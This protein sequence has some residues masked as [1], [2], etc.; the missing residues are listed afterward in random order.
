MPWKADDAKSHNSKCDS[1][2]KAKK[3]AATANAAREKALKDGK[4]E[5]EADTSA[6]RISNAA[7]GESTTESLWEYCSN[8]GVK[9]RVDREN[10]IIFGVKMLGA[11][12]KN[13]GDRHFTYPPTTHAQAASILEGAVSNVDHHDRS[14]GE[15]VSYRDRIGIFR[16]VRATT[17]GV[18]GDYHFN[19]KHPVAEQL[20][21][22]AEHAP[23]KL[24][25]SILAD[26][27]INRKDP[28][29]PVV[30][31]IVAVDSVDL[32][33][34][35]ATTRGLFES[36]D[37]I[38]EDQRAFCESGLSAVSDA[39]LIM[40]GSDSIETK[41]TRLREVLAVWQ[42]ELAG[43]TKE[44]SVMEYKDVTLEG[45]RE[46]CPEIVAKLT[47]TDETSKLTAEV[48][49]LKESVEAKEKALK[50]ANDKLAAEAADRAK[51]A[52]QLA[53]AE[54]LKTAK[55]NVADKTICTDA[56]MVQLTEAKDAATRKPIIDLMVLAQRSVTAPMGGAAPF[57]PVG[58]MGVG[59]AKDVKD[60]M[61]R[62]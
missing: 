21:W 12:S 51:A 39:R 13:R 36:E 37:E 58:V 43:E 45:L 6:I 27:K 20:C 56:I 62:L 23:E 5:K 55:V 14:K 46:H 54:E 42:A 32:V 50:E 52:V 57:T 25:F 35:P 40:L 28:M 3:W 8:A 53:I 41:K 31:A 15:K 10:G 22:D 19:M 30:E 26:G 61:A 24:G 18:I 29:N 38:P 34:N 49:T 17:D 11:Q 33:A 9:P 47:G 4:S 1:P 2:E 59:P 44:S 7:I 16:N 60:L 48:K